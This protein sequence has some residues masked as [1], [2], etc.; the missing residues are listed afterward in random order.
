MNK[1]E[2]FPTRINKIGVG[3]FG[4]AVVAIWCS[5]AVVM[6][7]SDSA[8]APPATIATAPVPE[9]G[10]EKFV[11][12]VTPLACSGTLEILRTAE[13]PGKQI[14]VRQVV[15]WSQADSASFSPIADLVIDNFDGATNRKLSLEELRAT[16]SGAGV[17]LGLVHFCGASCCV[18][19]HLDGPEPTP[20]L[21]DHA[22]VQQWI[23]EKTKAAAAQSTG[24]SVN[25]S[26]VAGDQSSPFQTLRDRLLLDVS[27]RLNLPVDQLQMTFNP[28]DR[29]LLN[30]SEPNFRFQLE[31]RRVRDLGKVSWE[32]TIINGDKTQSV[33]VDADA[34][35]WERQ[36]VMEKA[37][38]YRQIIREDDISER[39]MLVDH[40]PDD[41]LLTKSQV[42]GQ[43]AARDLKPGV[44][45]TSRLIDPVPLA[46]Q[47]QYVTITLSQ[48]AVQVRT[49]ARAMESGSF[50]QTIK[51]KNEQTQDVYEV[52]LTGPQTAT[53]GPANTDEAKLAST[54]DR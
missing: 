7:Q 28:K 18:V 20:P 32:V 30:L 45:L 36:L 24:S 6:P 19:S 25:G 26:D 5:A 37:A 54:T 2:I 8:D 22:V 23:D 13:I 34:R 9:A 49:V 47:G 53:M 51:V 42:V 52:T 43:Q 39:R 16:L 29:T 3:M 50:G 44:V 17:N 31:P 10:V 4:A 33:Q 40:M 14:R 41:Q 11:P 48:G 35:A 15:R 38:N 27:Q 21:D 1:T 12:N 46:H